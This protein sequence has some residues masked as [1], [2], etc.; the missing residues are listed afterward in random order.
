MPCALA[1]V[2]TG[3]LET[4]VEEIGG[5]DGGRVCVDGA[6][7][8]TGDIHNLIKASNGKRSIDTELLL[9]VENGT[10]DRPFLKTRLRD[11][12]R[13]PPCFHIEKRIVALCVGL[14]GTHRPFS[15]IGEG[16]GGVWNQGAGSV[17][18]GANDA[19]L[20]GLR[21]GC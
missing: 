6:D 7:R 4:S 14:G 2:F 16:D 20:G 18:H 19:A 8:I 5:A 9:S 1:R 15:V 12:N 10:G 3:K 13:I 17:F 21:I 11:L